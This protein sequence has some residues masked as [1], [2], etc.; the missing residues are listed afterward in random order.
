MSDYW[1]LCANTGVIKY[2]GKFDDFDG[3]EQYFEDHGID[4][5]IWI[6]NELPKVETL[7]GGEY[8]MVL[9]DLVTVEV[10]GSEAEA[11]ISGC[12]EGIEVEV[13]NYE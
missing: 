11:T 1:Y 6:F 7:I 12:P 4:S 2:A 9:G 8:N 5:S 10:T 13:H 3:V